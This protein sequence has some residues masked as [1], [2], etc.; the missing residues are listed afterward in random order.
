MMD[1]FGRRRMMGR[2]IEEA[3]LCACIMDIIGLGKGLWAKSTGVMAL[4][5]RRQ[6]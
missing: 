3:L 5:C 1:G 4:A 6:Y 2:C